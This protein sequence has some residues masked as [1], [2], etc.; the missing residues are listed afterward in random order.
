MI[1]LQEAVT[2]ASRLHHLCGL[3]A[4]EKQVT[5][6]ERPMWQGSEGDLW[7]TVRGKL[8]SGYGF[9]GGSLSSQACR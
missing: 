5:L 4:L 6:L 1:P 8:N 3:C 9:R 2:S 7:S